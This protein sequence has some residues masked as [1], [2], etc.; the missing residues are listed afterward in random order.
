METAL[1]NLDTKRIQLKYVAKKTDSILS[2][3]NPEAI[4]RQRTAIRSVANE[5]EKLKREI[6]ALKIG[7]KVPLEEI[8]TWSEAI[9]K[10]LTGADQNVVKINNWSEK[11]QIDKEAAQREE[12]MNF[13]V[14]LQEIKAKHETED[15]ASA[16]GDGK[17]ET[18]AAK[19][20]KI[21]IAEFNGSHLDWPRFWGQFTETIEKRHIAP[22]QK[23][24]YLCGYLSPKVKQTVEALPF[25]A[26]GYNRAK[27]ILEDKYGKDSE[28]VKAY[29]KEILDLPHIPTGN[30][31]KIHEFSDKLTY[32][33]QA[34]ETMG[35]LDC[36]NGNA[37][38]TLDKLP[39][40]RGNLAITDPNW[41]KW[42]LAKLSEAVRLWTR[43]NPLPEEREES[44]P[45]KKEKPRK[46]MQAKE[47]RQKGCV[48]C[49]EQHRAS[50]CPN[51]ASVNERKRILSEKRLCFNCTSA[52]H[53]A[54][55]CPSKGSCQSCKK[56][57]HTSICEGNSGNPLLTASSKEGVMPIV[58]LRV[59][60]ITCRALI[61]TGAGSSY[62]SGKLIDVLKIKPF[63]TATR[64]IDMLMSTK[65]MRVQKFK[66]KL[67]AI[68]SEYELDVELTKV[69]RPELLLVD[70]PRYEEL[71]S[72]YPYLRPVEI[73]ETQNKPQL[74]VHLVLGAGEYARIK[75]A[76]KPLV[77]REGEPVA[78]KTK[79][80]W[81]IMSPGIE[82]DTLLFA[83]SSQTD[84]EK[85][86]RLD[87]L[88]LEDNAEHSQQSVYSEFKEQLTRSSDGWYETGLPWRGRH[89]PLPNNEQGSL[90][91]LSNLTKRLQRQQLTDAYE[92]VIY[93][94]LA[95]GI[96]EPAP[97]TANGRTFYIPHKPVIRETAETT[98]LR[99]VY[100]ASA[101]ANEKAPSLN[102]CLN[103]GLA[104]QNKLW[105][106]LVH[107][108]SYPVA[109]C[110]DIQKAFLQIRIKEEER[111]ALRFHWRRDDNSPLE[112]YRFTRALFGLTS[113]PFL[114]GGVIDQHLETWA[115][116]MPGTIDQLR[117]SLYVD[118]LLTGGTN[119]EEAEQ[120]KREAVHIFSDAGFT[121]H[122]WNS[123]SPQLEVP[124]NSDAR[125]DLT[126]AKEQLGARSSET[127]LLGLSWDKVGDTLSVSFPKDQAPLTKRGILS[128]LAKVYDP[129][130]LA[131]PW[132]LT[133]KCI[134]R[135]TCNEKTGWDTALSP[136]QS[137]RWA[138]WE[139][140]LPVELTIPRALAQYREPV[141]DA[142]LHAFGDAST[143]GV[144][145]AVFAV[146]RQAT[147]VTQRLVAGRS[148]LAK[149]DLT[150]PRLELVAAHMATNLLMNVREALSHFPITGVHAWLD[151]TGALHWITGGGQYKQFVTNRVNKITQYPDIQWRH[152][153]TNQ[154]PA[155]IASRGGQPT[156]LWTSGPEWLA[157]H[158][159]WPPN[160]V[161][162]PSAQSQAEAKLV[163]EVLAAAVQ[164]AQVTTERAVL[165][166][167]Y[168]LKK[169]LRIMCW[170][171]R[172][173]HNTR[174]PM[175]RRLGLIQYEAMEE[176]EKEFVREAQAADPPTSREA[177]LNLT[178][179]SDGLL[180]CRGRIVGHYPIYIPRSSPLAERVAGR[181]HSLTLHGG[182]SLTM[183]K[184]RT[185]YWI[186]RL[187]S[188]VK[189]VRGKC[190]G[191]R[192]F[193]A[194][195]YAPTTHGLLPSDR[196]TP[197]EPYSVVGVDFAGPIRHKTSDNQEAKAYLAI[198]ACSLT[199][200]VHLELLHSLETGEFLLS[201]KRFMVRRGRPSVIYS[202]NGLTFKAAATW[203]ED[204]RKE[205]RFQDT[206]NHHAIKW[207]FNLS[208]APWWGGQFE[209]LIGVF[210]SAFR[211]TVGRGL[212]TFK[213]LEEVVL[214][215]ELT[216][217]ER[218][219]TYVEDDPQLTI[220]TPNSFLHTKPQMSIETPPYLASS[221]ALKK[222]LKLL[223][224]TKD[225][226]WQ[227]WTKEYLTSL[228]ERH[229]AQA[230]PNH[231]YPGVGDIV[232]VSNDD[233]NRNTWK[234]AKVTQLFTGRDNRVRGVRLQTARGELERPI[235][236]IY[237]LELHCDPPQQPQMNPEAREFRPRR[238]AAVEAQE[239]NQ[240]V[241][242]QEDFE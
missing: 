185:Q 17:Q 134:Y 22:I 84:Y 207:K 234:L 103:P 178:R 26:E 124:T 107:Q 225:A 120:R 126:F 157:D 36:V 75:V 117:R 238:A 209:R 163:R 131:A 179:N 59:N 88:G 196:T 95:E 30:V 7:N 65:Q 190:M 97:K 144:G 43:R 19:L 200:G 146:V 210:K 14:K 189:Q 82:V 35:R 93:E 152:V 72:R 33:V 81:F 237:P 188:L 58:L 204:L 101:K 153:P 137:Q 141:L 80:G 76:E 197:G 73:N 180:E 42:N 24:A 191:C 177:D 104:L 29:I 151:S 199:R 10:E 1:E 56:R 203:L 92:K 15:S 220:L 3:E 89:N 55:A 78:E 232:I 133:G 218:P 41:E 52:L 214:D 154:N 167:K 77:G 233:K 90:K 166:E 198:F 123:N 143:Q 16:H 27:A 221:S 4:E 125:E 173:I 122:K 23:F 109:V 111:D 212:L 85:L 119:D 99:V 206:L 47:T 113:S 53:R 25:T 114:L 94:Q 222:Q 227:R 69:D 118:D 28:V 165:I 147:G 242:L 96:I 98:K 187:R 239:R 231:S 87:V 67:G 44:S 6:E 174:S 176:E 62:A 48:Y 159:K 5:V 105:S 102:D 70:N 63:E 201:L 106:V 79:L 121:L 172:F 164:P 116:Q 136:K 215:I 158:E 219:L 170:V 132:T 130:G 216:M 226:L 108:R 192:R 83:K 50:D 208:R 223:R 138:K 64:N 229:K 168:S 54:A 181:A 86:C 148:R 11:R 39:A 205:E 68:D 45:W 160:P 161:T 115:E 183:A 241:A 51:V 21:T 91:R 228:R 156:E 213:H 162:E 155:D 182:V 169:A 66:A 224:E 100:D 32:A 171:R 175:Q 74:P 139:Q 186:P 195:P 149:Q 12:A 142:E 34:L 110:G 60:G 40:I 194:K 217:N 193:Q 13:Q 18:L 236:A 184:V 145:A 202:D 49:E 2:S 128:K 230:D 46:L 8:D 211:K 37:A 20:P 240:I 31:R 140:S 61:D 112:T 127:K 129:L 38:M 150:V 235:Q 135:D 9:D 71:R 57:H